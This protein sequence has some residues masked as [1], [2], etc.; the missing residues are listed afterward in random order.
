MRRS[1]ELGVRNEELLKGLGGEGV[2]GLV[3][4]W[5]F[6]GMLPGASALNGRRD[7]VVR[8]YIL[9]SPSLRAFQAS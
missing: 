5:G 4:S 9:L 3:R 1:D 6:V 2:R 8:R 7:S